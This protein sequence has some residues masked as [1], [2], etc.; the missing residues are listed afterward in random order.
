MASV[1]QWHTVAWSR[2]CMPQWKQRPQARVSSKPLGPTCIWYAASLTSRTPRCHRSS[3]RDIMF[4][5]GSWEKAHQ[6][7]C[8]QRV[9]KFRGW[10]THHGSWSLMPRS[11][12]VGQCASGCDVE[13]RDGISR[14]LNVKPIE[15]WSSRSGCLGFFSR[16]KEGQRATTWISCCHR[17][18]RLHR[19]RGRHGRPLGAR[20]ATTRLLRDGRETNSNFRLIT[21]S[22]R[23][24]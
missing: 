4:E 21:T 9:R 19:A 13:I 15:V 6:H 23:T 17:L 8:W 2:R 12:F 24:A 10:P 18:C 3:K 11:V 7:I 14:A 20:C 5:Y 16:G 1:E 22:G